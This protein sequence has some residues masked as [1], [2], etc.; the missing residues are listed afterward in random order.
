MWHHFETYHVIHQPSYAAKYHPAQAM[1]LTAGR[2]LGHPIIGACLATGVSF[3]ALMWML[4]AWLP[5]RYYWVAVL[6]VICHP[7]LQ[8][9]WGQ[10][11]WGGAVALTGGS[12]LL[13]AFAKLN[14][15]FKIRYAVVA[16]FGTVL[17]ANSRPF[18]GA[19]LTAVVG[20][21]LLW[22]LLR[23]EQWETKPF[24][25]KVILPG[26]AVLG[27]GAAWMMTYNHAVTG[28]AFE[29]PYKIHEAN[30]GWTPL[31][32]WQSPGKKPVYRHPDMESGYVGDKESTESHFKSAFDVVTIKLG[33]TI[34]ILGF[35]CGG[36]CLFA[37][38]GLPWLLKNPRY[39]LAFVRAIPAF[40]AGMATPWEW[41][42][43]CAPAAPLVFLLLLASWIEFW[44][45]TRK[46]PLLRLGIVMVILAFQFSWTAKVHQKQTQ[47][48]QRPWANQ[49]LAI[50]Q[51][52]RATAGQDL[53]LVRYS[54]SHDPRNEWVYNDADID[55]S[56]I[57]WARE[58]SPKER[59]NLI[60]YFSGRNVW[61]LDADAEPALL[62][63]HEPEVG[64]E[65]LSLLSISSRQY[66]RP[67]EP[68]FLRVLRNT[69]PKRE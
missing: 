10:S 62:K 50:K 25:A 20:L 46:V 54:V 57:A 7:G 67:A 59:Q 23:S 65:D 68:I 45:R 55:S 44:R 34:R 5:R 69:S 48:R 39:K 64:S 21:G 47:I 60:N 40:F 15:D 41:A 12:L 9:V 17:L 49:R 52:L 14:K 13:G 31:F 1:T 24:L 43:Y 27:L 51:Q 61:V 33:S 58:I 53:V 38:L 2:W 63:P 30:Y 19:V 35:Y 29:M 28:N 37:I 8:L 18:E 22:K 11:Y 36:T 32:L 4:T 56:E 26:F 6:F 3:A 16:A 42:H 66:Q